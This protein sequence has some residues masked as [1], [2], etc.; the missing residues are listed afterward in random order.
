MSGDLKVWEERR[1]RVGTILEES[2]PEVRSVLDL[3][4]GD[5]KLFQLL[6]FNRQFSEL[7]GVDKCIRELMNAESR[8]GPEM[9]HVFRPVPKNSPPLTVKMLL[10]D[11]TR[12]G[13][14]VKRDWDAIT[15]VEVIEHLH[16]PELKALPQVLFSH[17]RARMVIVTTPNQDYNQ[18]IKGFKATSYGGFRHPDHKFEWTRDEF[19]DW[20][21]RCCKRYGFRVRFETVGRVNPADEEDFFAVET[22]GRCTQ[23]AIFTSDSELRKAALQRNSTPAA[24]PV[25]PVI[26]NVEESPETTEEIS[27]STPKSYPGDVTLAAINTPLEFR[28]TKEIVRVTFPTEKKR[29]GGGRSRHRFRGQRGRCILR[30]NIFKHPTNYNGLDVL[31]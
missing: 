21:E 10:G 8:V 6:K 1:S 27:P 22:H 28:P 25:T 23:I 31:T 11:I 26:K 17:F 16:L 29:S 30:Q 24:A 4:C 9:D 3:G 7:V 15:L 5:G 18:C 2:N 14:K 13:R 19:R 20:A 12:P